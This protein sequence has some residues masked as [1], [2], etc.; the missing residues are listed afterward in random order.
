VTVRHP[1]WHRWSAVNALDWY[2]WWKAKGE[3]EVRRILTD[4]W[5]PI[6]VQDFPGALDEY[7]R[8]GRVIGLM[9]FQGVRLAELEIYLHRVRTD[10]MGIS[11]GMTGA[12][13]PAVL[14]RERATAQ[15]LLR[16]YEAERAAT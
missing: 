3:L 6:G 2:D 15:A 14:Q 5:D 12:R 4:E 13:E 16:L 1:T 7:D 10:Y 11:F 9:L 8:Y